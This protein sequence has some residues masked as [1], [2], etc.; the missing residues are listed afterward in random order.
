MA[1]KPRTQSKLGGL[2]ALWKRHWEVLLFIL[3][4]VVPMMVR[5]RR[6]PVIINRYAGLGDIICTIPAVK[7]LIKCHLGAPVIYNCHR[8]FTAIPRLASVADHVSTLRTIGLLSYWYR[9]LFAGFYDF[10]HGDDVDRPPNGTIV[11]QFCRQFDMPVT[12]EHPELA[13]SASVSERAASLLRHHD[14]DP[15]KL[16]LIH[17][18]PSWPV[19]EWPTAKWAHLVAGLQQRGFSNIAQLGVGR[20]LNFG[21]V[22]VPA[23]PGTISLVNQMTL[24]ETIATIK[25]AQ[26][27]IGID[28][29]L[30]HVAAATRTP[31]VGIFGMTLPEYRFSRDFRENFVVSSVECVGCEH[32]RPRLHWITGCPYDIR[33]MK[34]LSVEQALCCCLAILEP[35]PK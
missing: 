5:H 34:T 2:V 8:D 15:N 16:I 9:C 17:P 20:Y 7:E 35:V 11:S 3:T 28:S 18:G 10:V 32:R 19:R 24:E 4:V 12:D 27:F 23:I 1:G 13:V 14:L 22:D 21:A 26:L 33:C 6:R 25:Q 31:S 30:L 29:G